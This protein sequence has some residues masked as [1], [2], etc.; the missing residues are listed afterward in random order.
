MVRLDELVAR[1]GGELIGNPA[2][3]VSRIASV[4]N[5][6][7][8]DLAFVA[9]RKYLSRMKDCRAGVVVITPDFKDMVDRPRILTKDPYLYFARVAQLL[10]PPRRP[11]AGVHAS[12]VVDSEIPTSAAVGA[13]AVIDVGVQLGEDVIIGAGCYVGAGVSIGAGTRLHSRV[14]VY[15]HCVIGRNCLIHSGAVIGSDG[16]GFAREPDGNWVKIPQIGRVLIGDDVEIGANTT[17]DRGALD[18]TV[19]RDG[20]KIDNLVQIAHNVHIGEMTAIAGCVG[21]AGSTH[22]GARCMLAGQ[23]G[24]IGH[25]SVTDDVVISAGT[26]LTKSVTR[27]GTYTASLPVQTHAEWIKNFAHLRHLNA[28][29]ERLRALEKRTEPPEKP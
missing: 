26:K 19:I 28:L 20:A 17:I 3:V 9:D 8:T 23:V 22:I 16:F 13:G 24:V 2:S 4:E 7:E 14:S 18:D 10:N 29:V 15:D 25:L 27:P 12:A 5:A 1:F 6:E 11:A 21:I